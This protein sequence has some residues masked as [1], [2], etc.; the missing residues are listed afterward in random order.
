MGVE[1]FYSGFTGKL[2]GE[3]LRLA[4][5]YHLYVTAGSDYHGNNKMIQPGETGLAE[6]REAPEGLARFLEKVLSM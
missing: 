6:M 1:A 4:E 5:K 2:T 3:L